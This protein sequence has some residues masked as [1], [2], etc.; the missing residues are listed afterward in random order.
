MAVLRCWECSP[1]RP[2]CSSSPFCHLSRS[3][4]HCSLPLPLNP[5][6]T[7]TTA[8]SEIR[9]LNEAHGIEGFV[10]FYRAEGGHPACYLFHPSGH[11]LEVYLRGARAARWLDAAGRDLLF[12]PPGAGVGE[13]QAV[14]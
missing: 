9:A 8:A 13:G 1:D 2:P 5:P 12:T 14:E 11:T 3:P 6:P 4:P 10:E 7:I